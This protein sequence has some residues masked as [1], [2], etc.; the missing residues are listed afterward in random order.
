MKKG[1]KVKIY[2][3]PITQ[4]DFEE[5]AVLDHFIEKE[6]FNDGFLEDWWVRFKGETEPVCRRIFVKNN[7]K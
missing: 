1:D 3:K 2:Q 7:I 6:R 5:V 4:E